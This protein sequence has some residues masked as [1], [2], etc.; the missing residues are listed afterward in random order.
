MTFGANSHISSGVCSSSPPR[1]DRPTP[2]SSRADAGS[3]IF[4]VSSASHTLA[5]MWHEDPMSEIDGLAMKVT[6]QSLWCAI[7]FT[8]FLYS[9][10]R[11]AI[12]SASV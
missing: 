10:W 3:G 5:W 4:A 6:L 1:N 8:P 7:S 2:E 9:A 11:S 12:S